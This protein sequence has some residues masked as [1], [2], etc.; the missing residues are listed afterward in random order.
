[1]RFS[2]EVAD[3]LVCRLQP[4]HADFCASAFP[5]IFRMNVNGIAFRL[6]GLPAA[7][8]IYFRTTVQKPAE[9]LL[10][11]SREILT[12]SCPAGSM[13]LN[14]VA[15]SFTPLRTIKCPP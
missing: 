8:D 11:L 1:M 6:I 13:T 14:C 9:L 5:V 7:S 3:R 10:R 4:G 12:I 2:T 15:S